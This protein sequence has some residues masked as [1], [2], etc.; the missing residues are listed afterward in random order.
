MLQHT[1]LHLDGLGVIKERQLWNAGV[2]TIGDYSKAQNDQL[3]FDFSEK[4]K[5]GSAVQLTV[6]ALL[7]KNSAFFADRLP[8]TEFYR[9][10]ATYP[11]ET[12]FIDLETTGLSHYYDEIT[13]IGVLRGNSFDYYV[14]GQ[15][16]ARLKK[17]L[18]IIENAK[19]IVTFNGAL[20]D[21]KFLRKEHPDL[22]IPKA[23]I[24]LRF[25]ARRFGYSGGQ[26]KTEFDLGIK[27]SDEVVGVA[28]EQA[29]LLWHEYKL[30]DNKSG[31]L[32]VEYNRADVLG[33]QH[34]LNHLISIKVSALEGF[35]FSC[36]YES[37]FFKRG[38]TIEERLRGKSFKRPKVLTYTGK[39]GPSITY[40]EMYEKAGLSDIKI[41]GVDLTG[42][43]KRASGCALLDGNKAC[44]CLLS[45]DEEILDYCCSLKADL[46]SI[47]SPL[48][49]PK[50]RTSAFDD[51]PGRDEYGIMRIAERTL[52][53]RGVNVYPSLL[54]SMQRLTLRGIK[55]AK[56]LRSRGIAVIESYPGAAQD[57][58][59]IPRKQKGLEYL[60]KGLLDFGIE[61]VHATTGQAKE[62]NLANH[63]ELDAITSAV[64]G[65][66]FWIG[67]FEGIGIDDENLMIIPDLK[68]DNTAWL[69]RKAVGFSGQ[70]HAG[71]TT[72]SQVLQ[73]QGYTYTRY[74]KILKGMLEEQ[75]RPTDRNELQKFGER[76][77]RK[78]GQSWLT[79]KVAQSILSS[80]I[81]VIDGLRFPE[82]HAGLV[83]A[84][85]PSFRHIF[86]DSEE[87]RRFERFVIDKGIDNKDAEQI[88]FQINSHPVEKS[89]KSMKNYAHSFLENNSDEE[90]FQAKVKELEHIRINYGRD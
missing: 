58:M 13:V 5:N 89:S 15:S 3:S 21:L 88:F 17:V 39:S 83:E 25:F 75:G 14:K 32:L 55:L 61:Y 31:S 70:I 6:N 59:G 29:P 18:N 68:K 4:N 65:L 20:F 44:S 79:R 84:F 10:A 46:V 27:R 26:K 42:S 69:N 66:F 12:V 90:A 40:S 50:G 24:D 85:G 36:E 9:I 16:D 23:H 34:I 48:S 76:I 57:I 11:A 62:W 54:P 56:E 43:S 38:A 64:V 49:L 22:Q 80:R 28:G 47:D 7:E 8:S 41:I 45:T 71:K 86:I 52:K 33:M 19:C 72:A 37:I 63:D 87:F 77:H 30:G 81:C 73:K 35:P 60:G 67:K 78:P 1:F 74:S 53:K 2:K 51:D 82:D